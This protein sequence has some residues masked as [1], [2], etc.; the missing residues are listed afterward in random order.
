[1]TRGSGNR[2]GKRREVDRSVPSP[3]PG[4]LALVQD[5]VNT[6]LLR[7]ETDEL[8]NP[9]ELADW[10]VSQSLLP[11]SAALTRKDLHRAHQ[12]REGLRA[13]LK[14]HSGGDLDKV[15]LER[16]DAASRGGRTEVRFDP[17]GSIR[18]EPASSSFADALGHL[19]AMVAVARH[20]ELWPRL[21]LCGNSDCQ[22]AFFAIQP[23]SKWCSRRC[24]DQMR[25]RAY[26]RGER[27]QSR[28]KQSRWYL[29]P[30]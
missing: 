20:Q 11:E 23:T 25:S 10:L 17:D 16:L 29:Y 24:G 21:K 2:T 8:S 15:A 5:F 26:R 12:A 9:Q 22:A 27:Y 30:R 19:L 28:P 1:M 18:F 7:R 6:I 13:L 4:E 14:A 3:A